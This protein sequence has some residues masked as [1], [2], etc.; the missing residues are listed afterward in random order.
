MSMNWL[1]S[2]QAIRRETNTAVGT[3]MARKSLVRGM[4]E[5]QE[6]KRIVVTWGD[7]SQDLLI[8]SFTRYLKLVPC[9]QSIK[10]CNNMGRIW[11]AL[12][13]LP[14]K[15]NTAFLESWA[16]RIYSCYSEATYTILHIKILCIIHLFV[17]R[18][19]YSYYTF[20]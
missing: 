16:C 5:V 19:M 9:F 18:N 6:Q 20:H 7:T 8:Y 4:S 17:Y 1:P 3:V 11:A 12:K 2:H 13:P 10:Q 14:S 15:A